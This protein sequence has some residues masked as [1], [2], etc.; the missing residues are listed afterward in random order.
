MV[1]KTDNCRCETDCHR[2]GKA[3]TAPELKAWFVREVLPLEA[4]LMQF[5]RRSWRNE[6]DIGD[7]CQDVYARVCEA[8]REKIPNPT[9]PF[10]FAIARNLIIDQVRHENVVSIEAVADPD[11][12]AGAA[13]VPGA[14]RGIM[15][16]E[17]L[18]GL[19][20]ALDR[21][22]PRC[23]E[24]VVLKKIEGLSRREI[25][26]RMGI[27]EKTVKRHLA[28]GMCALANALYGETTDS[29]RPR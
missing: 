2:P 5:L 16:R 29:R 15:A 8:A 23:R 10:V 26:M 25:A 28:N 17:E 27:A 12:L 24:A 20:A 19:Q 22:P 1:E 18:Y 7:L 14:E 11:M 13:D 4:A 21:L 6:S 3:A 9:K